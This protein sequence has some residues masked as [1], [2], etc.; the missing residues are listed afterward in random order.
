[1]R[2]SD[3][4]HDTE[5]LAYRPAAAPLW[6]IA[7]LFLVILAGCGAAVVVIRGLA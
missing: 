3:L 2:D 6:A 5:R 4:D 7:T 1:M